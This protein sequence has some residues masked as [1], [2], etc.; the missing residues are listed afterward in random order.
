[1]E[2]ALYKGP[3]SRGSRRWAQMFFD[4]VCS[5][6][7]Y[8]SSNFFNSFTKNFLAIFTCSSIHGVALS[9][10]TPASQGHNAQSTWQ[11]K[12]RVFWVGLYGSHCIRLG[13]SWRGDENYQRG[14]HKHTRERILLLGNSPGVKNGAP[15][16]Y[17]LFRERIEGLISGGLETPAPASGA[18]RGSWLPNGSNSSR[19]RAGSIAFRT[20]IA[21]PTRNYALLGVCP[22]R[23]SIP[24]KSG[25]VQ[26]RRY[27]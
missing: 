25:G 21:H 16:G 13:H 20:S 19:H 7:G 23:W 3:Y 12:E 11:R 26:P 22:D 18:I 8:L 27:R 10:A 2:L 14:G 5:G 1:M 17:G 15:G 9:Y 4:F 6:G 24:R